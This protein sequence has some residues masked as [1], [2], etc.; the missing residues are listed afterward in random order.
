VSVSEGVHK[1]KVIMV[2]VD[3]RRVAI[4]VA[5]EV[6]AYWEEQFFRTNPSRLQQRRW[7]TLMSVVRAAYKKGVSDGST[8]R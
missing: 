4:P 8:R 6:K 5:P 7:A 3:D 2:T 1:A